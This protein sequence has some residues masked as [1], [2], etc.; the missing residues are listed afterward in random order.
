MA[1]RT[2]NMAKAG[3]WVSFIT[4]GI[5]INMIVSTLFDFQ[6]AELLTTAN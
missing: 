1:L 5:A 2:K 3:L 4:H 6:L